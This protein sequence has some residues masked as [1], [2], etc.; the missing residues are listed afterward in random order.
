MR[1]PWILLALL[2]AACV[3]GSE[4]PNPPPAE[5][6]ATWEGSGVTLPEI[7]TAFAAARTPA[8]VAAR[9]RGGGLDD[10]VPCYRE[11]AEGLALERLV[12]AE[13]DDVDAAIAQLESYGEL[14]RQVFLELHRRRLRDEIEIGDAEIEARYEASREEYRRPGRLTLHNIF[15]RHRDPRKPEVTTAVLAGLRDRFLAGETWNELARQYSQSETRLRGGLVG[16]V[17]E[18]DLPPRL[19]RIA[20]GLEPGGVSEPIA[21]RGGAVLLH[22]TDVVAGA[23]LGVDEA[24]RQIRRQLLVEKIERANAERIAGREPPAGSVVLAGDALVAALDAGEPERVVYELAGDRLTAGELRALARLGPGTAAVGLDDDERE[25]LDEIVQERRDRQLLYLAVA[26][27]ADVETAAEAEDR[28]R[29]A[30]RSALVDGLVRGEMEALVDADP[31]ALRSYFDDNRPRYQSP[32]RFRLRTWDL[33]FGADPPGQL[34]R[35]EELRER[36]AAGEL[37][38]AAAAA[39][40]GGTIE[41]LGWRDFDALPDEIPPKA[42]QYLLQAGTGGLS[43]PYQQDEA[44][45]LIEIA[46]REEPR[47]LEYADVAERVRDDYL[48][49]FERQLYRRVA[50]ERL[51]AAGFAFDEEAVRRLLAGDPPAEDPGAAPR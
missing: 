14:R 38:L 45:H 33:P 9:R 12:L 11:L 39:E 21:V 22:V 17:A 32:L 13:V 25:R 42:R 50:D 37:D 1:R 5:A 24:R 44:I 23:E 36:V 18:G 41:D 28:L 15:R 47:P 29:E 26:E 6:V 43:V 46:D 20:F 35:M 7:E 27:S 34:R 19:E 49:R 8:C 3:G 48:E 2:L 4:E 40:L 16:A 31:E 51:A 30:G 10:L